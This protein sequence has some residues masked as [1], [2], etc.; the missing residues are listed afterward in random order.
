MESSKSS[1]NHLIRLIVLG[2]SVLVVLLI[3]FDVLFGTAYP[4]CIHYHILGFECPLCGMTRAV[5][6]LVHLQF[7]SALQYNVVVVLLPVFFVLDIVSFFN[8]VNWLLKLKKMVVFVI[9]ISFLALYV[10]RVGT[11]INWF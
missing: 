4:L 3:P 2:L 6:A 7:L 1:K 10:F 8:H 11:H 9:A 5:H